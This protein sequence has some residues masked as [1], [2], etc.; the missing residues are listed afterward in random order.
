M[1]DEVREIEIGNVKIGGSNPLVLM[2]GPCVIESED[3]CLF[4]AEKLQEL[5]EK[6][7]IQFIFKASYDK[8]N[9]S[10]VDSYRG[11]GLDMG[12][13]ILKKVK[14]KTGLPVI[15]DVH[16]LIDIVSAKDVLDCLQI[17]AFLSRQTDLLVH[18]GDSGKPVAVKKGQF[19]SPWD[20][21]PLIK[22]VE[23]TGNRDIMIT[24]RGSTFGYNNLVS[25][26]RSFPI[27]REMGVPVIFDGT[28]SVQL[29]GGQGTSSGGDSSK[30]PYLVRAACAAGIDG[31]FLEVHDKPGE[32][33][34]DGPNMVSLEALEALLNTV[35]KIDKLV[36]E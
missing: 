1:L 25:D 16:C 6:V 22:K 9:R 36:R 34:C 15:S 29:P 24:E 23:S 18:A 10:S 32:A 8:A 14:A 2:A 17:P 21:K 12:L 26:M 30:V 28:H 3:H 20:I 11:P 7:G 19:L 35:I 13:E 27:V 5:T 31:L 4:M 33:L